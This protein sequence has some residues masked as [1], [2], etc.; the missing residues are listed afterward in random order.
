MTASPTYGELTNQG[1]STNIAWHQA[2][3]DRS[4]RADKRGHRSS[5]LWFTGL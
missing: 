1:A 3:V 5:I 2:S 4:A